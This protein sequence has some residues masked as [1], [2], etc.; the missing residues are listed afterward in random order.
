MSEADTEGEGGGG[1]VRRINNLAKHLSKL[2]NYRYL[3]LNNVQIGYI[4][5]Q[6]EVVTMVSLVNFT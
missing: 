1:V 5:S 4:V 2:P 6:L 3:I